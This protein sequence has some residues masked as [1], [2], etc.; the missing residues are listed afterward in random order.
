MR[1]GVSI[2]FSLY[3][4]LF[5]IPLI[6]AQ[7][8]TDEL[9]E[10]DDSA[11]S[12]NLTKEKIEKISAS[13]RIF[14][15]SNENSS[16][17]RGDFISFVLSD[18][19]VSRY[20]VAK[21]ADGSAAIK[22]MKIYDKNMWQLLKPGTEVA[23]LRGDDSFYKKPKGEREEDGDEGGNFK[24]KDEE[25]LYNETTLLEDD[26]NIE[27]K[28]DRVIKTDNLLFASYSMIEGQDL[29]G[30]PKRYSQF[31]ATYG[32]QIDD[33]IWTEVSYG[34]NLINDYPNT[35]L[36]T[37]LSNLTLRGKYTFQAPFFSYIQPY[38]G[39][40]MVSA[41]SPGAGV[42]DGSTP[43]TTLNQEKQLVS[44]LEKNTIIVG[45]TVLKRLVPGWFGRADL[46]TDIIGIGFGLEF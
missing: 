10:A 45:V 27:E 1:C 23:V 46:G 2:F 36:D 12:I 3:F 26:L 6:Y 21:L 24:I 33:N 13:K 25:D 7:A 11:P 44:T 5:S 28:K 8:I 38:L 14:V 30:N 29:T 35:G 17:A 19:L 43:E 42:S 16:F 4:F 31:T 37:K 15:I 40:Q 18:K 39:Y 34:Q 22:V 9:D 41:S 20:L 32:Y